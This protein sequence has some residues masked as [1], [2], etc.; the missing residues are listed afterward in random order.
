[1]TGGFDMKNAAR[2]TIATNAS[3]KLYLGSSSGSAVSGNFG[4]VNTAGN[5]STFQLYGLPTLTTLTWGGNTVYFGTVYAP[6]AN[7][8]LNG[9]GST[10]YDF[11]GALTV[12]S[13]NM[14]GHFNVHFD[15]NLKRIG[16]A[17]G[18]TVS[19]WREL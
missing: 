18:F 11:Q 3:L 14:N 4:M 8:T 7:L 15:Q 17:S 6:E 10:L 1:V 19:S 16:P 12:Q 9:G 5:A 2:I 13:I